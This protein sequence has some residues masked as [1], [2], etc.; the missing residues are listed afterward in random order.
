MSPSGT[1]IVVGGLG[2]DKLRLVTYALSGGSGG[3]ASI[4]SWALSSSEIGTLGPPT[5]CYIKT[6]VCG[7]RAP[8]LCR[9]RR[10]R[11][12]EESVPALEDDER[13]RRFS[14]FSFFSD[15]IRGLRERPRSIIFFSSFSLV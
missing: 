4:A 3:I 10:R 12:V 11:I 15:L 7:P 2:G 8:H 6:I 13:S 14:F 5:I 9:R 1:M